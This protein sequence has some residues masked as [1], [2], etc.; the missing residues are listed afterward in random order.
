MLERISYTQS[1]YVQ[2]SC[3]ILNTDILSTDRQSFSSFFIYL[4]DL[5]LC[6]IFMFGTEIDVDQGHLFPAA[7]IFVG[8]TFIMNLLTGSFAFIKTSYSLIMMGP[9]GKMSCEIGLALV[10]TFHGHTR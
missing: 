8:I 5:P 10:E 7:E 3:A 4:F 6:Y 1:I 9:S 2:I